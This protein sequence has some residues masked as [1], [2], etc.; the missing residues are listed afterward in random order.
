MNF[1]KSLQQQYSALKIVGTSDGGIISKDIINIDSTLQEILL[2]AHPD[3]L[4]VGFG[5]PKQELWIQLARSLPIP[6]MIGVGGSL[7]FMVTKKRAPVLF[8]KTLLEW[9]YRSFTEKG[10]F[11]RAYRATIVFSCATLWW[12]I[13]GSH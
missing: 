10:H 5:A 12:I 11:K 9:L 8:Q 3:I 7:D 4:L 6:V 2:Q 1:L 13:T